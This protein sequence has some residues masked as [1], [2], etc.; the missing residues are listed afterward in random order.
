MRVCACAPSR[1]RPGHEL[2]YRGGRAAARTVAL[3]ELAATTPGERVVLP[4]AACAE[5]DL[6]TG[7]RANVFPLAAREDR[8]GLLIVAAPTP[9]S[10]LLLDALDG[11]SA[12]VSLA[13]E[14][15]ALSDEVHRRQ[16]ELRFASLVQN[17]SDLITVVDRDGAV[18]YQSPSIE[19]ILGLTADD[20]AGTPFGNLLVPADRGRLLELLQLTRQDASRSQAFECSFVDRD[21]RTLKFEVVATDLSDDEHVR[22]IVLNGRN[23]SE[24]AVFEERLEHQA[25]HDALDRTSQPRPVLRSRRPCTRVR[26]ARRH[27]HCGHLPRSRRLQD[28]QR[29][30]RSR[31]RRRAVA[32]H[33]GP[34]ARGGAGDR[35][36]GALRRGRVRNPGRGCRQPCD[37]DRPDRAPRVRVRDCDLGHGQGSLRPS[38]HRHRIQRSNRRAGSESCR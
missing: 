9:F 14:S 5:L 22:G 24:R 4:P 32:R 36:G 18:L 20:V 29:R 19:R 23:A 15:A 8:R 34:A 37:G 16:N 31:R 33:R 38:E 10:P 30:P 17:A 13:L 12:S 1:A 3:L 25:L 26:C 11:L 27:E 2:G 6:P 28:D 21:G 7:F 35:H